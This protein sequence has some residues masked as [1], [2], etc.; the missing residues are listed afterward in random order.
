MFPLFNELF[1]SPSYDPVAI[2]DGQ[3]LPRDI[4]QFVAY[5]FD[6]AQTNIHIVSEMMFRDWRAAM[7]YVAI[8][9]A[10]TFAIAR[11][12]NRIRGRRDAMPNDTRGLA[13]VFVFM[14]ASY[15]AWAAT[16][17]NYRYAV[18][19]E[20]L[21][22]VAIVGAVV[23]ILSDAQLRFATAAA[24][25]TVVAMTTIYPDWGRAAYGARYID[26]R[27]PPIPPGSRVLIASWDPAA[28]FI[29]YAEPSARYLGIE[30][31]FLALSQDNGL[32]NEVKRLMR[33][34][35]PAKFV[36]NVGVFDARALNALLAHFNLKLGAA[37]CRAIRSNLPSATLA[38]CPA[39]PR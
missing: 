24:A 13:V 34:P 25:L 2:R 26:V 9:A 29:P 30:N 15:L 23:A 28:Y 1:Q 16:F 22:G 36:V 18:V 4:W 19:L 32:A 21:T 6:W 12:A 14:I 33:E 11:A 20:M 38:L 3:F 27:V 8:L 5:P 17:G 35:G 37:P 7:A 10:L 39:V 31:N